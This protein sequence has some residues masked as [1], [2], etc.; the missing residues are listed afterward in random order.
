MSYIPPQMVLSPKKKLS[1]LDV[2]YDGG[3]ESWSLAKM[4]WDEDPNAVGIRWN[5]GGTKIGTPQ[6]RGIPMWFILP[7]DLGPAAIKAA[8]DLAKK[9]KE[10]TDK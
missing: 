5:G 1:N 2:L 10:D 3:E 9:Q 6:A 4:T 7:G 8:E